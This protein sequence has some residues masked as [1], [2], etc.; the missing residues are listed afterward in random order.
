M[1]SEAHNNALLLLLRFF[2]SYARGIYF[3]EEEND[4]ESVTESIVLRPAAPGTENERARAIYPS[5]NASF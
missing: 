4:D 2:E 3:K 5:S 1:A